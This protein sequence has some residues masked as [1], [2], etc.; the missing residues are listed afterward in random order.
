MFH[1]YITLHTFPENYSE[2]VGVLKADEFELLAVLEFP[3]P[4]ELGLDSD[5]PGF[6]HLDLYG[7]L[8]Q[9]KDNEDFEDIYQ[10]LND[11]VDWDNAYLKRTSLQIWIGSVI[12]KTL[13]STKHYVYDITYI[14][15]DAVL[16]LLNVRDKSQP[17]KQIDIFLVPVVSFGK[18]PWMHKYADDLIK[19]DYYYSFYALPVGSKKA[20]PTSSNLYT[21]LPLNLKA[22]NELL[23]SKDNFR[24]VF[25]LIRSL[26][27]R[28]QLYELKDYF[29]INT[30][31]WIVF[32]DKA[33][34]WESGVE[35]CLL[36]VSL[37]TK[38]W[39]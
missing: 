12:K 28:Y 7:V 14:V 31:Q 16:H 33:Y 13:Q 21:F 2:W 26:R 10:K 4:M 39:I 27:D 35:N 30:L 20:T 24:S 9:L 6:V 23:W 8:E 38:T 3:F 36:H 32:M 22:E 1:M 11:L 5:R 19:E 17:H 25:G 29:L 34:I 18:V 15:H 37:I